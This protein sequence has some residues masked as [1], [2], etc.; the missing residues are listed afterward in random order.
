MS[1]AYGIIEALKLVGL[2]LLFAVLFGGIL[3]WLT[4]ANARVKERENEH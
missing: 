2:L 1:P 4:R 3:H